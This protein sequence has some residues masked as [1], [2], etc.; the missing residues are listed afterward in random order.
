MAITF[1]FEGCPTENLELTD[2][3]SEETNSTHETPLDEAGI[4]M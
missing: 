2:L 3:S 1:S 4:K